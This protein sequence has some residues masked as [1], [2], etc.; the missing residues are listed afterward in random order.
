MTLDEWTLYRP[1]EVSALTGISISSV[2]R[3]CNSGALAHFLVESEGA[4]IRIP[5]CAVED[6][7][8][9]ELAGAVDEATEGATKV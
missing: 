8:A 5:G 1:S 2:Y 9:D 7:L 6:L 3:L 4:P